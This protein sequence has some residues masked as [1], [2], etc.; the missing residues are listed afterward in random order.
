M[1]TARRTFRY[2]HQPPTSLRD[3]GT[4][5]SRPPSPVRPLMSRALSALC[6]L[7]P[8]VA[9][10]QSPAKPPA[11]RQLGAIEAKSTELLG[12]VSTARALSDGRVLINDAIGRRVLLFDKA[13]ATYTVVA[14]TTAATG[15]AYSG[16]FGGL[17]AY[18]GDSS[19]FV[20]PQAMSMLVIDPAGK[21]GRVM[22]VPR[23]ND[24]QALVASQNG[25]PGFDGQG[26]LVYRAP[27]QFRFGGGRP[28][29]PGGPG[30][31][32]GQSGAGGPGDAPAFRMP[33]IPDS[34]A[35]VRVE[36]ATRK[37]D[38][39]AFIKTPKVKMK[40]TAD[41]SGRMMMSPVIDP[42]PKVDDWAV[43]SNGSVAI[44]RGMDY[45]VDWI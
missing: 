9:L 19:L 44:V 41:T 12:A 40:Q 20:D 10:A 37:L 33:D 1:F 32:G 17:L 42:L 5:V 4:P 2:P 25:V 31:Q 23:P 26:R 30:G 34:A 35:I 22:S 18:K 16:R 15:N 27:F 21:I 8:G 45:H 36:L 38:T 28:G 3:V 7:A 13:L 43:L 6:L 24:A 39:V 29:G 14:D 11:P